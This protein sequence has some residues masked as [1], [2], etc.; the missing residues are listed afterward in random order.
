M[1]TLNSLSNKS[2]AKQIVQGVMPIFLNGLSEFQPAS[3]LGAQ[4]A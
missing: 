4:I 1:N 3:V 2:G